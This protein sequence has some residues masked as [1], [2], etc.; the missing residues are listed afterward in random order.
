MLVRTPGAGGCD[1]GWVSV[2]RIYPSPA[3]GPAWPVAGADYFT[4]CGGLSMSLNLAW[5][6]GRMYLDCYPV[7]EGEISPGCCIHWEGSGITAPGAYLTRISAY[8]R[9]AGAS[10]W[11]VTHWIRYWSHRRIRNIGYRQRHAWGSCGGRTNAAK[12]CQRG[13]GR[14][15]SRGRPG[16]S[17]R[18]IP[19]ALFSRAGQGGPPSDVVKPLD[20]QTGDAG[21][22]GA[23]RAHTLR[24]S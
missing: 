10:L 11:W 5:L 15:W 18:D 17:W 21:A 13:C 19:G 23:N 20:A 12:N 6:F 3:T 7:T 22:A 4:K 1:R 2:R 24:A 9:G 8:H 16:N 14:R